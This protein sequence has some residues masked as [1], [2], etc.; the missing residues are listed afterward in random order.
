ME[1]GGWTV[2]WISPTDTTIGAAATYAGGADALAFAGGGLQVAAVETT[3]EQVP[4]SRTRFSSIDRSRVSD[5]RF[6]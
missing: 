6:R 4:P 5:T 2:S 3:A 1:N